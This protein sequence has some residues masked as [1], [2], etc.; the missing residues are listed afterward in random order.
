MSVPSIEATPA[1]IQIAAR[2]AVSAPVST[3]DA[4]TAAPPLPSV[5]VQAVNTAL[6]T[7]IL[8]QGGLA[9]LIADLT[10]ALDAP[11]TPAP[12][13][14]AGAQVLALQTLAADPPPTAADL[15]Q[16]LSQ[17]GL[18]LEASIA[19]GQTTPDLKAAL[20][21]L[22]K[23]LE[24]WL[25]AEASAPTE[26]ATAEAAAQSPAAPPAAPTNAQP[27]AP[28]PPPPFRGAPT[29]AQPPAASTLAGAAPDVVAHHLM[30]ETTAAI[31]RTQ[32]LQIASLPEHAKGSAWVFDTPILTPQGAAVAQFQVSRDKREQTTGGDEA[33][34]VWRAG[35]SID[36]E[37]MGP[38]HAQVVLSGGKALVSLW[39]ERQTTADQL[40]Q[41]EPELSAALGGAGFQSEVAVHSGAPAPPPTAPGRFLD[42]AS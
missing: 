15:Q 18:M 9:P 34:P 29:N 35:F 30:Q 11:T 37:P 39:A 10:Q 26:G 25:S 17:S 4:P 14:A 42:Q 27:P 31:A 8:R 5:E 21:V 33:P 2:P 16:A 20:L 6:Q 7:A 19:A 38:V 12:V 28:P 24:T 36:V 41:A 40:T 23:A 22:G 1:N 32:L 13:Q 3:G